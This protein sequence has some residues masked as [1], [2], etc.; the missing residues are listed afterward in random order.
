M[1]LLQSIKIGNKLVSVGKTFIVAEMSSNHNKSLARAKKIILAAKKSG[2]DAIKIQSYTPDSISLNCNKRDF[3]LKNLPKN[4]PWRKY[5]NHYHLYTKAFTPISWHEKLFKF[6]KKNKIL[7]FSSP[8]DLKSVDLLESLGCVAYKI[9]SPEITHL[10]LLKKVALTKKPIIL[11]TGVAT[12]QDISLAI[13]TIK[14]YKNNNIIILKCETSYPAK[15]KNCN[16]NSLNFLSKKFNLL[17]GYSDHTQSITSAVISVVMGGCFIERHFNLEDNIKTPDSFFSSKFLEFKKMVQEVRQ[18]EKF[19]K[20]KN[21]Y[22]SKESKKNS[23]SKRSIYVS[24][25]VKKNDFISEEN[26]KIVR[27]GY[28]LHPRYYD[29]IIGK[30]FNRKKFFGDRLS[31]K[32]IN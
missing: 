29:K 8:F 19:D 12:L 30:K 16:L 14:K 6:A 7:I 25:D 15:L 23:I 1:R 26:I 9:A 3:K 4:S 31:L 17:V 18:V 32:D 10:P 20:K 5:S 24:K 13:K 21:Y 27:P 11:S 28:G 22:L 2:A